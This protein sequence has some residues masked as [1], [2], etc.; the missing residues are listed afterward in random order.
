MRSV[1]WSLAAIALASPVVATARVAPV[2]RAFLEKTSQGADYELALAHTAVVDAK[3]PEVRAYA[4]R[5]VKDH[6]Q[7]NMVL[8]QLLKAEGVPVPANMTAPDTARLSQLKT[9]RGAAFDKRYI[10]EVTRINAEDER[11]SSKE[12]RTTKDQQIKSYLKRFSQMDAEHKRMGDQ[13][14][15]IVG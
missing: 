13:L 2:D 1:I 8:R 10:A 12:S 14:K 11:E 6:E 15:T 4:Q 7:A 9:L 3:H 5:I